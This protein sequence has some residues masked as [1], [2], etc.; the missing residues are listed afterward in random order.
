MNLTSIYRIAPLFGIKTTRSIIERYAK[1][2]ENVLDLGCGRNSLILELNLNVNYTG[3]EAFE[4]YIEQIKSKQLS[5]INPNLKSVKLI[6]DDI[7]SIDFKENEFDLILIIDVIEHLNKI[8]AYELIEKAKKWTSRFLI[9]STPNGFVEQAT[10]DKNHLQKHIS[11]WDVE[12]IKEL[13]FSVKGLAGLKIL[14]RDFH[15]TNWTED[16]SLSIRWRPRKIWLIFAAVSQCLVYYL[17][18]YAYQ[19]I[20]TWDKKN[21]TIT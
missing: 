20:G 6:N 21:A 15:A 4:P 16:I 19:I 1:M 7:L 11:G 14:R 3:V 2:S 13:G 12:E 17:P 5:G 8:D 18:K 9:V 10:L